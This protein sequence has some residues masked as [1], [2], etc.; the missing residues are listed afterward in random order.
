MAIRQEISFLKGEANEWFK[1]NGEPPSNYTDPVIFR[2]QEAGIDPDLT[3]EIGCGTG[4]R[5]E[6]LREIYKHC[7]CYGIDPSAEAIQFG[8]AKYPDI[9]LD[10]GT[11]ADIGDNYGSLTRP[12]DLIIFGFC[13]YLIDRSDLFD[14][15]AASDRLLKDGGHLIIHDFLPDHP[16]KKKY[17]HLEG[18]FSY[19]MD[20]SKLWL[21][22]PAY[23]LKTQTPTRDGEGITILYKNERDA[24][25]E[26]P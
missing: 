17:R 5:L 19:K 6:R 12:F 9:T 15:V 13:L 22:S 26:Q 24:W 10:H 16:Q 8:T 4:W 3:L 18:V 11:A 23:N 20:Y 7:H 14:A 1:R 2:I 25:P 21:G